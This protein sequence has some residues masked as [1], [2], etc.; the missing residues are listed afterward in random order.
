MDWFSEEW[1]IFLVL[2]VRI[3][4]KKKVKL[5]KNLSKTVLLIK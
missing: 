1:A 4:L 5:K 3:N 2:K